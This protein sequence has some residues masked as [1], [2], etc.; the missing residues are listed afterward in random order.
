LKV[1]A[2]LSVGIKIQSCSSPTR[3][4]DRFSKLS[5]FFVGS[6]T[7]I[8]M[9]DLNVTTWQQW[10]AAGACWPFACCSYLNLDRCI[11]LNCTNMPSQGPQ[12]TPQGSQG[13]PPPPP[14]RPGTPRSQ[15]TPRDPQEPQE[16]P[17]TAGTPKG[18][19]PRDPR[20]PTQGTPRNPGDPQGPQGTPKGHRLE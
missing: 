6:H 8:I 18:P 3:D 7:H 10:C 17:G 12:G 9:F 19:Q 13:P 14:R 11:H 4:K 16:I 2:L 5:R 20:D 15:V 1:V